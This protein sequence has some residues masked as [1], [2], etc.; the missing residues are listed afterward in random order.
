MKARHGALVTVATLGLTAVLTVGAPVRAATVDVDCAADR[1]ALG[2]AI[3]AA[4]PGDTL[5]VLG[6]C[7]R[8]REDDEGPLVIDKDLV[9]V[10]SWS[11][12]GVH[13]IG[14]IEVTSGAHVKIVGLRFAGYLYNKGRLT[15]RDVHNLG[16]VRDDAGVVNAGMLVVRDSRLMGIVN[17]G[18]AKVIRSTLTES[19]KWR[20]GFRNEGSIVVRDSVLTRNL[21]AFRN[22]ETGTA[23]LRNTR[24]RRNQTAGSNGGTLAVYDSVIN[25]N[26]GGFGN[27]GTLRIVRS[28]M[29][30]NDKSEPQFTSP[31]GGA[32]FNDGSLTII[33]STIA[34]NRAQENGGGIHNGGGGSLVAIDSRIV[35]NEAAEG[36]GGGIHNEPGSS[37]QL[38]R[39]VMHGNMPDDCSGC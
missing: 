30:R 26:G 18:R 14:G 4:G 37:V 19:S 29:R 9:I 24:I 7:D 8:E 6:N 35:G 28:S 17:T 20:G 32:A 11:R 12:S 38:T 27:S 10:G 16:W 15:L 23:V 25:R 2:A 5:M 21:H 33:R 13:Y 1:L 3:D 31:S 34:A 39:V 36:Q 22:E